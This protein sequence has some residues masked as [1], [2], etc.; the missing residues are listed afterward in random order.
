MLRAE[1][2]INEVLLSNEGLIRFWQESPNEVRVKWPHIYDKLEAIKKSSPEKFD[3]AEVEKKRALMDKMS[4]IVNKCNQLWIMAHNAM[5]QE[6]Y[7]D[8]IFANPDIAD[9]FAELYAQ[10]RSEMNM[11][12]GL[13]GLQQAVDTFQQQFDDITPT[14]TKKIITDREIALNE[15][16]GLMNQARIFDAIKED[17]LKLKQ[18]QIQ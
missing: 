1:E 12:L 8:S 2:V 14:L 18:T 4:E 15:D 16:G 10:L 11:N 6:R 7:A 5:E 17:L 9:K 13:A 3:K